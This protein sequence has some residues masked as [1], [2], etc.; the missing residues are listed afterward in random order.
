MRFGLG[1][2][3]FYIVSQSLL[4]GLPY[5]D[6]TDEFGMRSRPYRLPTREEIKALANRRSQDNP[7]PVADRI[8]ESADSVWD[9]GKVWPSERTRRKIN[10]WDR[11]A[12]YSVCWLVTRFDLLERIVGID[13]HWLMFSPNAFDDVRVARLRLLYADNSTQ[14]I[15]LLPD[16]PDLTRYCHFGRKRLLS[17]H[18]DLVDDIDVQLGFCNYLMHKYPTNDSG[19]TLA[20]IYIY[21]IDYV[22]PGPDEDYLR[23]LSSQNGPANWDKDG[24]VWYYDVE[25]RKPRPLSDEKKRKSEQKQLALGKQLPEISYP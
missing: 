18:L 21:N 24:P 12:K 4:T 14:V 11:A 25:K 16:P 19:K 20:K 1:F 6:W 8:Y 15:R 13:Q 5:S 3:L 23:V 10:S 7:A 9:F 2:L 17:V 22:Y